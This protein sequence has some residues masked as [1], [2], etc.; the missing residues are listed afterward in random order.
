MMDVKGDLSGIA[1]VGVMNDK[2]QGRMDK[3]GILYVACFT[4]E[5]WTLSNEKGTR[6]R[7]T[8]TEF[9]GTFFS[10]ILELNDVQQGVVSL[11][12]KYCG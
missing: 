1:A 11:I 10:K 2:I 4:V 9:N 5:F 7:A 8:V 3:V 6:L 12:F